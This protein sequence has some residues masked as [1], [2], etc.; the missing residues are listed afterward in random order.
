MTLNPLACPKGI[1]PNRAKRQV[2]EL[3]PAVVKLFQLTEAHSKGLITCVGK[4]S[5]YST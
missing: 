5:R 4:E 2:D 3:V 1:T